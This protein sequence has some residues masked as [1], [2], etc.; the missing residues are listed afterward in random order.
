VPRTLC[1]PLTDE[2]LAALRQQAARL[3]VQVEDLARAGVLDLIQRSEDAFER[4]VDRVLENN[5][6]L[7]ARLS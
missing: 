2:Q 4:A 1:I 6:E 7:Y 3:G 5:A